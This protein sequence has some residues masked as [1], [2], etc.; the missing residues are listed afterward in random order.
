MH[1]EHFQSLWVVLPIV[2]VAVSGA[3]YLLLRSFDPYRTQVRGR[4]QQLARGEAAR[5]AEEGA[6]AENVELNGDTEWS[7]E[8]APLGATRSWMRS[9]RADLRARLS[10]A[11]L[12]DPQAGTRFVI[13]RGLLTVLPATTLAVL[14]A[15]GLLSWS[16]AGLAIVFAAGGGYLIPGLWLARGV[17]RYRAVLRKGLPDFLDLVVVCLDAGL[18]LQESI[19]R[20]GDELRL[21]HPVFAGELSRVQR[22]IEL[23]APIDRALRRFAD[24]SDDDAVRTLSTLVREG[25]RFGTNISE[26]LRGHAEMLRIGREQAAEE[27]AQKA[28]VKI[29]LPTLLFIFP[30][31]FIVLVSPAAFKI[32]EAF[33]RTEATAASHDIVPAP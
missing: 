25:Q 9:D 6:Y 12:H 30:A 1:S 5:P 24:R 14:A 10:Q 13:A 19:R 22:D 29:L 27:N 4:L 32:Q 2:F 21:I 11:G 16:V 33:S 28:S 23:G 26:A 20:V 15:S 31:I 3:M 17:D 7:A 18:S 8:A